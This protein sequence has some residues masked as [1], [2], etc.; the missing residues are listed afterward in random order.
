MSQ[1]QL[2]F[3]VFTALAASLFFVVIF[4]LLF[5]RSVKNKLQKEY[6]DRFRAFQLQMD[7]E[8]EQQV[9]LYKNSLQADLAADIAAFKE[10]L[11]AWNAYEVELLK[12]KLKN[13]QPSYP[14]K[15]E[16]AQKLAVL[17]NS[18][19][20]S[21]VPR[22]NEWKAQLQ[23]YLLNYTGMIAPGSEALIVSAVTCCER[24]EL[25]PL[26]SALTKAKGGLKE[27]ATAEVKI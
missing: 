1:N 3:P 23:Q 18:I 4:Y 5:L 14:K 16:S 2:L 24:Q 13:T 25:E 12:S 27:G 11:K 17:L 7:L 15:L 8:I 22:F 21:P 19:S 9:Q 10:E 26:L 20:S 6:E